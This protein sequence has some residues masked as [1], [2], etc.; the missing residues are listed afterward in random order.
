M[1]DLQRD[2]SRPEQFRFT[3][4]QLGAMPGGAKSKPCLTVRLTETAPDTPFVNVPLRRC[5]SDCGGDARGAHLGW[6]HGYLRASGSRSFSAAALGAGS[7]D[8]FC[9]F[10]S[11]VNPRETTRGSRERRLIG[12]SAI[13]LV[14]MSVACLRRAHGIAK[15]LTAETAMLAAIFARRT[16]HP[17]RSR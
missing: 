13:R 9:P 4:H 6:Y 8:R 2:L 12:A 5:P 15:R 7:P 16:R 3:P 1:H 14:T 17:Q 11:G 10:G